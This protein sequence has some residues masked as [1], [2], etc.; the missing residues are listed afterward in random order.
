M[1]ATYR[2]LLNKL[3]QL[4]EEQLDQPMVCDSAE[5]SQ[6]FFPKKDEPFFAI[7]IYN[8]NNFVKNISLNTDR[9]QFDQIIKNEEVVVISVY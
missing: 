5:F 9:T 8:T 1:Y 4:N 7:D 2:D 3:N 6:V